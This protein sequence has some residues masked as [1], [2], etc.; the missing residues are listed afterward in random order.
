MREIESEQR[1]EWHGGRLRF[2]YEPPKSER[3]PTASPLPLP[4]IMGTPVMY[5]STDNII[6]VHAAVHTMDLPK[7][8][9][10]GDK[11]GVGGRGGSP[12]IRTE[13]GEGG[14]TSLFG[15]LE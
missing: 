2:N 11:G 10:D 1:A 3:R 6:A 14:G 8:F 15:N 12:Y 5:H 13:R 4:K 9:P 7:F